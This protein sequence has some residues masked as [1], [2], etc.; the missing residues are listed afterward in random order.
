MMS[1]VRIIAIDGP[2][3]AGKGTISQMLA[4]RLGYHYL[5]SGALY[6]LL[7]L[8]AKHHK[9]EWDNVEELAVLA[10]HMDIAFSSDADGVLPQI[11]LE[12]ENVSDHIRTEDI[13]AGASRVA[14]I[15]QVRDALLERQ[16]AFATAPGLVADGRDMGTVVF[17]E[18]DVKIFLTASAQERALRRY[19]QL[20][21]KGEN[22]SLADLTETVR[23]RDERDMN[24]DVSPLVPAA[25]AI[26]VDTTEK[27]VQDVLETVLKIVAAR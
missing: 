3:G 9:V 5:D 8:A 22:V 14:V 10:A 12:G 13:G 11:I 17:P 20:M 6:R 27:S 7:A 4:A 1:A 21:D 26:V 18:A 16:R 24:R 25:D 23:S 15:P 19:N 2:S